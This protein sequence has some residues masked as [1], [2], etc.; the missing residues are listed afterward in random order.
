MLEMWGAEPEYTDKGIVAHTIC[1]NAIGHGSRKLYYYDSTRL[2][3]CY[4]NCGTFD[5]F[6]LCIK[7]KKI[8][9]G[10]DWELYDAMAFIADYFGFS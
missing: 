6:D 9:D 8:Q 2:F 1:H 4:S 7:V 10:V 5:I 3:V